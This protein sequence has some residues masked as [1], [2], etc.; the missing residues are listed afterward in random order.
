MTVRGVRGAITVEQDEREEILSAARLLLE[1]LSKANPD[2][3][4]ADIASAIFTLTP[5]LVS[6]FPAE[7]ARQLGWSTVPLLCMQE[8]PVPGALPRCIRVLIH[9]N[10]GLPQAEIRPVYLRKAASLRPDLTS[11]T[12]V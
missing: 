5:D 6:V 8:I 3:Q 2:L 1:E 11:T 10:T 4:P 12:Q 9:W 7:A